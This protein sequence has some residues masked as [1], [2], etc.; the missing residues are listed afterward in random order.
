M[1][2]PNLDEIMAGIRDEIEEI[3]AEIVKKV[4]EKELQKEMGEEEVEVEKERKRKRGE[5]EVEEMNSRDKNEDF[6]FDEAFE[7]MQKTL[8]K[9]GFI[10]ERGF[11]EI[12]PP[13]KEVIE[14]RG[15]K[16]ICKAYASWACHSGKGVL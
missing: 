1:L 8:F 6:L 12:I 16:A 5:E 4:P 3:V 10:G 2:V 13:F 14:K 7:L 9:K 15:W 11:K